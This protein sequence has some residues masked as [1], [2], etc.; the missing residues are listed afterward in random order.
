[1]SIPARIDLLSREEKRLIQQDLIQLGFL[2]QYL[3][4]GDPAD[5]GIWGPV[6]DDAYKQY[7]ASRPVS[8]S[9][10][11]VAPAPAEPWWVS[12]TH[13]SLLAIVASG[14]LGLAGY[15]V[16]SGELTQI[17]STLAVTVAGIIGLI[18]NA[19]R[20]N[21]IDQTLV[22]RVSGR[23]IRLGRMRRDPVPARSQAGHTDPRGFFGE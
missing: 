23:D 17:L 2:C 10:P 20:K 21:P 12:G 3:P 7:W 18:R 22:A 14:L 9:V 6:T 16:D 8:I 15:A 13:W 1:M 5:D 11:V 19:T 4:S